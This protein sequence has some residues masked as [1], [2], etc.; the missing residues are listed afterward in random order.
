ML[1]TIC[2]VFVLQLAAE[3]EEL[4]QLKVGKAAK[5]AR[6]SAKKKADNRAAKHDAVTRD[7]EFMSLEEVSGEAEAGLMPSQSVRV[8]VTTTLRI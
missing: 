6:S 5:S 4:R 3:E 2:P 7:M 1:D 8:C